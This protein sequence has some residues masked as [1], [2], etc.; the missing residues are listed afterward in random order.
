MARRERG[1][2]VSVLAIRAEAPQR[3]TQPARRIAGST[4]QNPCGEVL[5]SCIRSPPAGL[6]QTLARS[7]EA[8]RLPP[9]AKPT[10]ASLG[11][12]GSSIQHTSCDT[13]HATPSDCLSF[14]RRAASLSLTFLPEPN[15]PSPD[16]LATI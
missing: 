8:C 9:S 4:V 6:R 3:A 12:A 13:D 10:G 16:A 11:G 7:T 15:H 14:A 2:A 5:V 1:A